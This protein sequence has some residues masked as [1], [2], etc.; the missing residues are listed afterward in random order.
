MKGGDEEMTVNQKELAQCLGISSRRIR[1]LRGDGLFELAR[2]GRGYSL[3]KCIQ[4]YIDYKVNAET[5]RRASISKEQIQA[6]HEEVKMKIS[7]LKLRR[8]RQELHEAE[9]VEAFM[10][11]MLLRFK[12]RLLSCPSKLAMEIAGE[13][14]INTIILTIK[15]ELSAALEELSEYDPE[16]IDGQKPAAFEEDAGENEEEYEDPEEES[17]E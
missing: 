6:E 12:N 3:E 4:E 14:D 5:G 9:D 1:Q 16:E 7:K 17:G 2:E 15:K 11:A 13:Q 8:L 10:S